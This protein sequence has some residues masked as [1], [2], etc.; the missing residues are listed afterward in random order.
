MAG[1]SCTTFSMQL[2]SAMRAGTDANEMVRS[3]GQTTMEELIEQQI[4]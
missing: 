3:D 1:K 2:S 4:L